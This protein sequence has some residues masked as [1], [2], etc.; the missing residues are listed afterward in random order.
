MRVRDDIRTIVGFIGRYSGENFTAFGTAFLQEYKK[1]PYLVTNSHIA[2]GVGNNPFV[3]RFTDLYGKSAEFRADPYNDGLRWFESKDDTVDLAI[4]P[5]HVSFAAELCNPYFLPEKDI[6]SKEMIEYNGIGAGD[7][8]YAVGLFRLMA[9]TNR[10]IPFVHS[11]NIGVMASEERVP[12]R[13]WIQGSEQSRS[14]LIWW[15]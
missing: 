2:H 6:L 13:D 14:K 15:K 7:V 5:F 11:G 4:M 3:I 12:T 8:C 1:R 9:G 10:N